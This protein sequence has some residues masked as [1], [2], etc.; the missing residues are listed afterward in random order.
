MIERDIELTFFQKKVVRDSRLIATE[1]S[2]PGEAFC[3]EL[4][5][6]TVCFHLS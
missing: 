3:G 4:I 2:C 1:T 6:E 5:E